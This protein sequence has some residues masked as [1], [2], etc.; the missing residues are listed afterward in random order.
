M[1]HKIKKELCN[2]L[3][4]I[5]MVSTRTLIYRFTKS[6]N[7]PCSS[8][9]ALGWCGQFITI[10]VMIGFMFNTSR[11]RRNEQHYADDIFKRIF[12][13]E[14]VWISIKISLKFVPKVPITN[15]P[16]L[17]QIMAWH[18][19]GDKPLS[20]PMIASLLTYICVTRPQWVKHSFV[21]RVIRWY[22]YIFHMLWI[23]CWHIFLFLWFDLWGFI[24]K[25]MKLCD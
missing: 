1:E 4:I 8:F 5:F 14:D 17:V 18:R 11:P 3:T 10:N 7:R 25:N 19:S 20:E 2:I 23:S 12:F 21:E 24:K 22:I 16:S 9:T 13:N 15:I 6:E